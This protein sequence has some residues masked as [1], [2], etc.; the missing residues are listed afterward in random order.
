[1]S[2]TEIVSIV[3]LSEILLVVMFSEIFL[4]RVATVLKSKEKVTHI[5]AERRVLFGLHKN[6][7][8]CR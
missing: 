4:P 6:Q 2:V 3:S 5:L 8:S 7:L 1:M